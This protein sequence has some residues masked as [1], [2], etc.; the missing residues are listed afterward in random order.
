MARAGVAD[1]IAERTLGHAITGVEG[2]YN[3]F[4]YPKDKADALYRLA[5]LIDQIV[6]PPPSAS[7]PN[8]QDPDATA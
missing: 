5:S 1:H 7:C 4:D 8:G 3:R 2:V 6:N